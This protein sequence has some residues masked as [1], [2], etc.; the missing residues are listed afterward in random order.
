MTPRQEKT[1]SDATLLGTTHGFNEDR[2]HNAREFVQRQ[3]SITSI[4]QAALILSALLNA[5]MN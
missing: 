4:N 2:K 1:S 5:S 3:D